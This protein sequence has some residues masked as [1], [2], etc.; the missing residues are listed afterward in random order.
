M[1]LQPPAESIWHAPGGAYHIFQLQWPSHGLDM[2]REFV[3][4]GV[5]TFLKATD[6]A[7]SHSPQ[8]VL[9]GLLHFTS[10]QEFLPGGHGSHSRS[11]LPPNWL[12]PSQHRWPSLHSHL[13]Q[14]S[15][16]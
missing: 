8:P 16:W 7:Q 4:E 1:P 6:L 5:H 11:E 10:P 14:M 3:Y 12:L 15:G 13:G 2:K 9:L